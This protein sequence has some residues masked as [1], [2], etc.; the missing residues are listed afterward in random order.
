MKQIICTCC[1]SLLLCL[2]AVSAQAVS[3][4]KRPNGDIIMEVST[5]EDAERLWELMEENKTPRP[6]E[7]EAQSLFAPQKFSEQDFNVAQAKLIAFVRDV[8]WKTGFHLTMRDANFFQR[9][10][11]VCTGVLSYTKPYRIN[12]SSDLED[13]IGQITDQAIGALE[14]YSTHAI[15]ENAVALSLQG[16]RTT[17][18]TEKPFMLLV[19]DEG[20]Y[21]ELVALDPQIQELMDNIYAFF[22]YRSAYMGEEFNANIDELIDMANLGEGDAPAT[23]NILASYAQEMYALYAANDLTPEQEVNIHI[24][25]KLK[26]P[27][28]KV[29][30]HIK[31]EKKAAKIAYKDPN[32]Q[33]LVQQVKA[34]GPKKPSIKQEALQLLDNSTDEEIKELIRKWCAD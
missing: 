8:N 11:M 4:Y 1:I 15:Y 6:P 29:H 18:L 5:C 23:W 9:M 30:R 32:Y 13:A 7:K 27:L 31:V 21:K 33:A 34:E 12:L 20:T 26:F 3:F 19:M 2:C 10:K 25:Q 22:A 28:E 16:V 24:P 14:D 17:I